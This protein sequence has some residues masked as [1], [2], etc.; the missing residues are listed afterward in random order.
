MTALIRSRPVAGPIRTRVP[1]ALLLGG[2]GLGLVLT[3]AALPWLTVYAGLVAVPGFQ[4]DGGPLAGVALAAAGLL[5]AASRMGGG[6]LLRP[7]AIL[8]AAFVAA[9]AG[10]TAWRIS[11]YVADPG[12]AA[13]LVQPA[14]GPGAAVMVAGAALLAAA[15]LTVR[16]VQRRLGRRD[17]GQLVLAGAMLVSGWIHLLLVPE[18]LAEA[19]IL[20]IGF[21]AAGLAQIALAAALLLRR[22]EAALLATVAVSAALLGLYAWAVVVGL[23]IAGD[24]HD[25][26]TAA[27]SGIALFAGE[28]IDFTGAVNALAEVI[29]IALAFVL[30]GGREAALETTAVD[31]A[32]PGL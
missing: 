28:A 30:L 24:A 14:S 26:H 2:A 10:Y 13:Q 19:Q 22:S 4:L 6:R 25:A 1:A 32:A 7:A 16:P 15:A 31:R 29:G 21:A 12:P 8:M 17:L 27:G 3:A 9:D 20:G 11:A 23:P 18:H 5:A